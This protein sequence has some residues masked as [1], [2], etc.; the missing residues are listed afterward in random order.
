ME[1]IRFDSPAN[2]QQAVRRALVGECAW[3]WKD[4]QIESERWSRYCSWLSMLSPGYDTIVSFNYDGVL[5][6][7]LD[8]QKHR[9]EVPGSQGDNHDRVNIL[10][11]HGSVTC[12]RAH[13]GKPQPW[14]ILFPGAPL[15]Q[16]P[17]IA[18]LLR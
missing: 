11:L 14:T 2:L 7:I 10:K 12:A 18:A 5:E 6:C 9:I 3:F 15:S 1:K 4:A 17:T 13:F 16:R 8:S